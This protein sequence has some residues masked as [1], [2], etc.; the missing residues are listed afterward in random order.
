MNIFIPWRTWTG[1]TSSHVSSE[2]YPISRVCP[3][4]GSGGNRVIGQSITVPFGRD[5]EC[6]NCSIRYAPPQ[7]KSAGIAFI[8][9]GVLI[10]IP[11]GFGTVDAILALLHLNRDPDYHPTLSSALCP[12]CIALVGIWFFFYGLRAFRRVKPP[13]LN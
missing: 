6:V 2:K 13:T 10:L 3:M 4:C 9:V 5:R 8:L 11:F 12:G 1:R 7:C